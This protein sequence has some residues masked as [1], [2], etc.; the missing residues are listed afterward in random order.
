MPVPE[1][2]RLRILESAR[3]HGLRDDDLLR[4]IRSA[5]KWIHGYP[6]EGIVT[7][8]GFDAEGLPIEVMIDVALRDTPTVFHATRI[9]ERRQRELLG[10]NC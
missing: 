6:R 7:I 4:A 2:G 3:K 9:D 10:L 5:L 8:V 1:L